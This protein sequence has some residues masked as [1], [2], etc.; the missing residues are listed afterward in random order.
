[1]A[2]QDS[3]RL[4]VHAVILDEKQRV[5]LLKSTYGDFGWGLPGGAVDPG[6]TVLDCLRRECLEE[7]GVDLEIGPLT[8]IYYHARFNSHVLL[9]RCKLSPEAKLTLSSEHSEW[10]YS[11]VDE[12][13]SVQRHRIKDALA[14]D[15]LIR[16]AKF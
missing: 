1:M 11:P 16:S 5:L 14:Y 12:L 9:F 15:G 6:E 13:S 3:Y 7:V 4:S 10:K 8:G 2:Y